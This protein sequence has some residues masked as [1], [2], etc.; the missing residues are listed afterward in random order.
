MGRIDALSRL[1]GSFETSI[2]L[3]LASSEKAAE[4]RELLSREMIDLKNGLASVKEDIARSAGRITILEPQVEDYKKLK[5]VVIGGF[6]V[7]SAV[8]SFGA[9]LLLWLLNVAAKW[10]GG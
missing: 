3:L 9:A 6:A 2:E 4:D 1:L 8:A 10:I 7:V 5:W